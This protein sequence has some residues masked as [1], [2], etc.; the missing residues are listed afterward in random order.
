M[1]RHVLV[2]SFLLI[3]ASLFAQP[4]LPKSGSL[5]NKTP[6]TKG[7]TAGCA[8]AVTSTEMALNNV[9]ALIHTGGDMWWDF[10]TAQYEVPKGSGKR[11]YGPGQ[12]GLEEQMLMVS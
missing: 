3:T 2:F 4:L 7:I 5:K 12:C 1:K 8:E 9:R 10:Q 11:L 6:F